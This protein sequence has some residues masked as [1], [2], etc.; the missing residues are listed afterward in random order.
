[1][2]LHGP[3]GTPADPPASCQSAEVIFSFCASVSSDTKWAYGAD[4]VLSEAAVRP[5]EIVLSAEDG[6]WHA[7]SAQKVVLLLY[8]HFCGHVPRPRPPAPTTPASFSRSQPLEAGHIAAD[9]CRV[10]GTS[11]RAVGLLLPPAGG[12]GNLSEEWRAVPSPLYTGSRSAGAVSRGLYA[13]PYTTVAATLHSGSM[14]MRTQGELT[15]FLIQPGL[16]SGWVAG[17]AQG[18]GQ[19]GWRGVTKQGDH[20]CA[21]TPTRTHTRAQHIYTHTCL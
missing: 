4:R 14:V 8:H 1:M 17:C 13:R 20:T 6:V 19:W 3:S 11:C 2:G 21:L 12:H 10:S 5:R 9:T 15:G 18:T 7:A 16:T